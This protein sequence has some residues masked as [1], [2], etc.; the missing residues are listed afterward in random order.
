MGRH[1]NGKLASWLGWSYFVLVSIT[2]A[3]AIPLLALT[4]GGRG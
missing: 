4:H 2:A 1:V 3:A